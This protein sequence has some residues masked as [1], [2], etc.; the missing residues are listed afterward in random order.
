MKGRGWGR[1]P[2]TE[3][4]DVVGDG[5]VLLAPLQGGGRGAPV[6]LPVGGRGHGGDRSR[7]RRSRGKEREGRR[8]EGKRGRK[9]ARARSK[10][11]GGREPPLGPPG[12]RRSWKGE[13]EKRGRKMG[14]C[15]GDRPAER[16]FEGGN[17]AG[18]QILRWKWEIWGNAEGKGRLGAGTDM[19]SLRCSLLTP[20]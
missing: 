17:V 4:G 1:R 8:R 5:V 19:A 9:V 11:A 15:H 14:S 12:R 18:R 3:L 20:L 2:L 16:P 10:A 7:P 6:T 13:R